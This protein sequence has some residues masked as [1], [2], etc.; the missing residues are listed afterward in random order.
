MTINLEAIT[1][2]EGWEQYLV[3]NYKFFKVNPLAMTAF[4]G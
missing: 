1:Q 4:V 2:V 3:L